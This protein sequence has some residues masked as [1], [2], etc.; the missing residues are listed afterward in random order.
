[1]EVYREATA[2]EAVVGLLYLE[3]EHALIE[4]L[5]DAAEL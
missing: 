1:M 4:E 3:G 5:A 2:L